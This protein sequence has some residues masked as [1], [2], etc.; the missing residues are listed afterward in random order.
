MIREFPGWVAV[1]LIGSFVFLFAHVH[2]A[3]TWETLYVVEPWP[4]FE[5]SARRGL[6]DPWFGNSPRSLWVTQEVLF[7]LAIVIGLMRSER[8]WTAGLVFW[9]GVMLPLIPFLL[10]RSL[11]SDAGFLA[12]SPLVESGLWSTAILLE[13]GRTAL[14]IA[15]GLV[16]ARILGL[17]NAVLRG[18]AR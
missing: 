15:L 2:F 16:C 4:G 9:L 13:A 7:A 5:E 12:T 11:R 8:V 6:I 17:V 18:A 10:F 1:L 3:Q 14:P